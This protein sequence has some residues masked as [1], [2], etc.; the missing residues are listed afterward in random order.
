MTEAKNTEK[1]FISYSWDSPEHCDS[2]LNLANKLRKEGVDAEIDQY[3]ECP[4]EGWPLLMQ[5][6]INNATYVLI[7][8]TET[9]LKRVEKREEKGNGLGVTWEAS[10]IYQLLYE[11]QGFNTK[12]IPIIFKESDFDNIPLPLKNT[13]IYNLE[14]NKDYNKLYGRLT[15][16]PIIKKPELGKRTPLEAKV[17]KTDP[18][19]MFL[20]S[21]ID[22]DLWNKASW[23][24]TGFLGNDNIPPTLLIA[25]KNINY[26]IEIFKDWQK[27]FKEYDKN[28][29]IRI[30][31]IEGD[32]PNELPGYS[33]HINSNF[34][35]KYKQFE[36]AC[37]A[38]DDFL[39]MTIGRFNR[40]NPPNGKSPYLDVFKREYERFGSY[41]IAPAEYDEATGKI[42]PYLK[43]KIL[44]RVILFRN[45]EE[46]TEN[47]LDYIVFKDPELEA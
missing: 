7:V 36:K 12:F 8:C 15:G 28:D 24:G 2:V 21:V 34:E 11:Q 19:A 10:L 22:V 37:L 44:K 18:K 14:N 47:D 43:Y 40:M 23:H 29:E 3:E 32:I 6:Q 41:F 25:Y 31:I 9:Y 45:V 30:S 4:K 26:G 42:V 27:Y 17:V 1:V 35:F 46:I 20:T 5:N 13:T 16:N 38:P 39:L 33:V